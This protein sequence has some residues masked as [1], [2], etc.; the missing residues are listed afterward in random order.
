MKFFIIDTYYKNFLNDFYA[1]NP[2]IKN[3]S[4]TRQKELLLAE[5]FGTADFYSKNL[6]K[7]GHQAEDF[8]INNEILQ[9]QWAKENNIKIRNYFKGNW[10]TKIL[11]SQILK[12]KPDI[13]YVQNLGILK[14]AFLEKIK[15][16]IK[17]LVG[18]IACPLPPNNYLKPYHLIISSFP[19]YVKRFRNEG[20]KSE[21]LKIGFEKTILDKLKE[22]NKKY[23]AVFI[24]GISRHHKK[25]I[26]T[27]EYLVKNNIPIDFWGY[28]FK[29]RFLSPSMKNKYHG[30]SWALNMYN[31]LYNAKISI[32]RHIDVAENYANNMRLYESTGVGTMLIT[33]Y[34]DNLNELFELGR[35]IET[36]KS[37]EELLG[38]INYYLNHEEER[39]KIAKA[40]QKRTLRDHNYFSRMQKLTEII[41]QYL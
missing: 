15:K 41:N 36:Y 7:I 28:G 2:E 16:Y 10:I 21:Y 25:I 27:F 30:E 3:T 22:T 1:K 12:F 34:K 23:N 29:D 17:L 5:Q 8:I 11:E 14:P 4:Y 32:N 6:R 39:K 31:I 40:G 13:I 19:H 24:G 37:K 33:D 35:E 9:S 26:E 20:I 38:K 18:Q